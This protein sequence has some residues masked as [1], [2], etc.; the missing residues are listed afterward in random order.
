MITIVSAPKRRFTAVKR[1]DRA[2]FSDLLSVPLVIIRKE[3][4]R[5]TEP[6]IVD[7]ALQIQIVIGDD[8]DLQ[9]VASVFC[10]AE[11]IF[12]IFSDFQRTSRFP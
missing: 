3:K 8:L 1:A 2:G 4:E 5:S 12:Q 11:T 9:F 6:T 7:A 10:R